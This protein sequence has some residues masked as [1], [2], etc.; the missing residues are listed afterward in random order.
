M[1]GDGYW[2]FKACKGSWHNYSVK[3]EEMAAFSIKGLF[4]IIN[5]NNNN[6][7]SWFFCT[8]LTDTPGA[9]KVQVKASQHLQA[10]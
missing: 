7:K 6:F 10:Q 8:V 3:Y 1:S 4:N 9:L 2:H 5:N